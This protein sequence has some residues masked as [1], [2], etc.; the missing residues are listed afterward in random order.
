MIKDGIEMSGRSPEAGASASA[1][2]TNRLPLD[3]QSAAAAGEAAAATSTRIV[4]NGRMCV[5]EGTTATYDAIVEIAFGG[6]TSDCS[7]AYRH[8]PPAMREGLLLPDRSIE[9][10]DDEVFNVALAVRS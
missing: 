3:A 6:R 7:V 8:G 5:I 4:V 10:I 1:V 9:V 2:A